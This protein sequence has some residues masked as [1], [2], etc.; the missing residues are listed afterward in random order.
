[1]LFLIDGSR[2]RDRAGRGAGRAAVEGQEGHRAR[3]GDAAAQEQGRSPARRLRQRW[4]RGGGQDAAQRQA[5][6]PDAHREAA[7]RRAEPRR[8]RLA[9]AGLDGAVSRAG[10]QQDHQQRRVAGGEAAHAEAQRHDRRAEADDPA[11]VVAVEQFAGHEQARQRDHLGGGQQQAQFGRG[12]AQVALED[13]GHRAEA[14]DEER[15]RRLGEGR[16]AED[17]PPVARYGRQHS[18]GSGWSKKP[19]SR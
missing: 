5:R 3:Q 18:A 16:H 14:L 2:G 10:E 8:H 4:Q 17:D 7:L 1:M 15:R 12:Q 13:V 9:A 19:S 6:L 11:F